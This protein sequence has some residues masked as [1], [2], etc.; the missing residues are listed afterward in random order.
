MGERDCV[1][2]GSE[3]SCDWLPGAIHVRCHVGRPGCDVEEPVKQERILRRRRGG[4][5]R[6]DKCPRRC[7]VNEGEPRDGRVLAAAK[8]CRAHRERA[9]ELVELVHEREGRCP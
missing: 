9:E 8:S 3:G 1:E 5:S 4:L 6:C 2:E 7:V